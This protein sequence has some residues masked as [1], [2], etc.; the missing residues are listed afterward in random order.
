M[1]KRIMRKDGNIGVFIIVTAIIVATI[2]SI[3]V[4]FSDTTKGSILKE[5]SSTNHG[6]DYYTQ[7][8]SKTKVDDAAK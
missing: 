5:M 3:G 6:F 8:T 7:S 1:K 4:A 2:V